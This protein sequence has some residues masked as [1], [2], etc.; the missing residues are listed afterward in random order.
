MSGT[1]PLR[2]QVTI[3]VCGSASFDDRA[4]VRAALDRLHA[5]REIVLLMHAANPGPDLHAGAWANDRGVPMKVFPAMNKRDRHA[6]D[7]QRR[8]EMFREGPDGVVAF[9]A[10]FYTED[11]LAEAAI[12][13][14]KAW[15]PYGR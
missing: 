3:I 14:I 5:R 12:R 1:R 9:P 6:D 8:L 13:G 15:R 7:D 11:L 4:K 10:D 2:P